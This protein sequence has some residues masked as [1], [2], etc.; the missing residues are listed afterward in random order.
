[1]LKV[2]MR[3]KERKIHVI[4]VESIQIIFTNV[5]ANKNLNCVKVALLGKISKRNA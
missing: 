1:M 3:H 5:D 4:S 2:Y